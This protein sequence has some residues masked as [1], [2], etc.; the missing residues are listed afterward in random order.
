[1]KKIKTTSVRVELTILRLT[2][3]RLSQLG[4]EVVL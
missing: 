3:S 2:V 1:M 4:H